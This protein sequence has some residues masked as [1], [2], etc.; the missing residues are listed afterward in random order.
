MMDKKQ[1]VEKLLSGRFILTIICGLTFA[2]LAIKGKLEAA[3]VTAV[4]GSVFASYFDRN[5]RKPPQNQTQPA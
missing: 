5:D 3:A 1:I 4:I 2:Y